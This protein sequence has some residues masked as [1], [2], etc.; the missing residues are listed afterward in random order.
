MAWIVGFACLTLACAGVAVAAAT[1]PVGGQIRAQAN[2]S[3]I[4][5]PPRQVGACTLGEVSTARVVAVPG[6]LVAIRPGRV[7]GRRVPALFVNKGLVS[8]FTGSVELLAPTRIPRHEVFLLGKGGAS[9]CDSRLLGPVPSSNLLGFTEAGMEARVGVVQRQ[10]DDRI[11]A[12]KYV[13]G[14]Y[15]LIVAFFMLYLMIHAGRFSRLERELASLTAQVA[16]PE[17]TASLP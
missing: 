14:V 5:A 13:A 4:F 16:P 7:G 15:L 17:D 2:D 10:L 1:S 11:T 8:A 6:D 9:A 3:V 12:E